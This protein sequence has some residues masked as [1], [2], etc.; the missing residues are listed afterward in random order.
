MKPSRRSSSRVLIRQPL[1]R[2]LA[3]VVLGLLSTTAVSAQVQNRSILGRVWIGRTGA[4]QAEVV[5]ETDAGQ[6][7]SQT[8]TDTDGRFTFGSLPPAV[9]EISV[10]LA[11]YLPATQEIN[12]NYFGGEAT[13]NIFLRADPRAKKPVEVGS[14]S[15]SRKASASYDRGHALLEQRKFKDAIAPLS[16]AVAADPTN[17]AAYDDLGTAY[18]GSGNRQSAEQA[19]KKALEINPTLGSAATNLA[20]LANDKKDPRQAMLYLDSA[21]RGGYTGWAYRLERGRAEMLNS[22]YAK[23]FD[24][25]NAAIAGGDPD[26]QANMMLSNVAVK[27]GNY[28]VAHYEL[29]QYLARDPKGPFA[30]RARQIVSEMQAKGIPAT[31]P[32]APSNGILPVSQPPGQHLQ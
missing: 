8:F 19:W 11:G 10:K 17:V 32:P 7:I 29:E 18:L 16:A 9:F 23:A 20:R 4:S 3:A 2:Y 24:D 25:F 14:P 6:P 31:P 12:L 30:P 28:A 15:L 13:V 26:P 1:G 5:L 21:Q 27:L 22:D